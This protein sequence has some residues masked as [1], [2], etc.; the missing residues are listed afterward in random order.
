[1]STPVLELDSIVKR[2]P[3]VTALDGISLSVQP[4]EV[5]GLIGENGAGK[6]TLVKIV[7]GQYRPDGGTLKLHGEEVSFSSPRAAAL[8]GIGIVHQEQSLLPNLTAAENILLGY[9][10]DAVRLGFYRRKALRRRAKQALEKIGSN[11]DVNLNVGTLSFS[12][13]QTVEL[14]KALAIE[15]RTSRTPLILLDEPTSV[16]DSAGIE[17]LFKQI[18]RLRETAS[19]IFISHRMDEV[20]HVATRIYVLRQGMCVGE[21]DPAHVARGELYDLMAGRHV[22]EELVHRN[23][24]DGEAQRPVVLETCALSLRRRLA[25]LDLRVS[26]GEVVGLAGVK[27]SGCEE[28][29]RLLFGAEKPSSGSIKLDGK[30]IVLRS[31]ADATKRGIGY[32]PA[33]RRAEG[34]VLDMSIADNIVLAHSRRLQRGPFRNRTRERAVVKE[35]ID[36]LQIRAP[37]PYTWVASLSGGNQQKVVL[38]KWLLN[39]ELKLLLLDHPTRGLDPH[40]RVDVYQLMREHAEHG[41]AIIFLGDTLEELIEHSDRILALR[42]GMLTR[43][44]TTTRASKPSQ[45]AILEAIV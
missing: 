17:L 41:V 8:A 27:D 13:R 21:R 22:G 31:P 34:V 37:G 10:E 4:H 7:A 9:E 43:E 33:E 36:R 40:T 35:W 15:E 23:G 18:E 39:P 45:A 42:D 19:V 25:P 28:V 26:E 5:V 16:L 30:P 20:L 2:F 24:V 12:Q 29:L 14:A 11:L 44:F 6:S 3:G 32:I 38:A 1:M